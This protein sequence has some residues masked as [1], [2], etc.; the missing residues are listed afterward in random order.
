M[1][2]GQRLLCGS[3]D[4]EV[5]SESMGMVPAVESVQLYRAVA[6]PGQSRLASA[7]TILQ[8]PGWL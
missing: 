6:G 2:K 5:V 1:S 3:A 8:C 7:F 4:L